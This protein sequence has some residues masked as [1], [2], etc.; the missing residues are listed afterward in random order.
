[1]GRRVKCQ[2]T[3][4]YSTSDIAYKSDNGKYW[5]SESAYQKW[6]KNQEWRQ[7]SIDLLF[8]ILGYTEHMTI[9]GVFWKNFKSYEPM[10][11]ETVYATIQGERSSIEWALHNKQFKSEAGLILYVCRI[12][13]NH[14]IDYY[15]RV[16]SLE[17]QNVASEQID[18]PQDIVV[19]N[20]K[21]GSKN[22]SKFLED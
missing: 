12:L 1:M 13:E 2:D 14:M 4:E 5:S 21:Q 18:I 15:K 16:I 20:R 19:E 9:P 22:I 17:Q 6:K 10:G 7:K 8:E 3:G 11:Y